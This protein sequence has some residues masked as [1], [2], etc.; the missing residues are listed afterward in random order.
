MSTYRTLAALAVT[1][2]LG[3]V[4]GWLGWRTRLARAVERHTHNLKRELAKRHHREV[5]MHYRTDELEQRVSE[6]T[7]VLEARNKELNTVRVELELA[8][9]RLRQLAIIDPLTG[10]PNRR[11]FDQALIR[12]VRRARRERQPVALILCDI[13]GFKAYNDTYGHGRGDETLRQVARIVALTFRRAGDLAAR[14]GGEE[15]GVILPG[16]TARK[17][18][19]YAERLRRNVWRQA[20]Q[21]ERAPSGS[22][23]SLSA[24]VAS[25]DLTAHATAEDLLKAADDALYRA[26]SEGRNRVALPGRKREERTSLERAS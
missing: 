6:R 13:D 15:F 20:I 24:G 3:A 23:I 22:C 4:F 7:A 17:A 25:L 18:L 11:A 8:N 9:A 21:H 14:Y 2:A 10:I 26:K 12:E 1:F 16:V 19:L 5:A